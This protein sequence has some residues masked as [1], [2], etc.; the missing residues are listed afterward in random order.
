MF[1]KI[2]ETNL[3]NT[4]IKMSSFFNRFYTT[5]H[6]LESTKWLFS[7]YEK[8]IA[9]APRRNKL[10]VRYFNHTFLQPSIIARIEGGSHKDEIVI[11]GG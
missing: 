2:S 8:I 4:I 9:T 6:G 10:S 3:N 7:Q 1:P 5:Q 11:I